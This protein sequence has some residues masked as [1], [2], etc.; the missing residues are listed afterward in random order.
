MYDK[1]INPCN[2]YIYLFK[3]INGVKS[4]GFLSKRMGGEKAAPNHWKL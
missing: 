3:I 4:I 2:K 1:K